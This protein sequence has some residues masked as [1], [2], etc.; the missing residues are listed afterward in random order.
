GFDSIS[1]MTALGSIDFLLVQLGIYEH[2]QSLSRGVVDTRDLVYFA[3]FTLLF[4]L[5][6]RLRLESSGIKRSLR[7]LLLWAVVLLVANVSLFHYFTRIDLT[8]DKRY[9]LSG[10]T[11]KLLEKVEAPL[12]V[13]VFL[14]GDLS[15]D[16]KRLQAAVR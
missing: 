15:T 3:S 8:A 14:K 10:I 13:R 16:I 7:V 12:V 5:A 11:R 1:R 4:L 2:Y 6:A 9:T